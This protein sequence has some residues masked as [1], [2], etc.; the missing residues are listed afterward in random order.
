M[1]FL[2]EQTIPI[3]TKDINSWIFDD[4]SYDPNKPVRFSLVSFRE[5]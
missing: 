1:V 5:S 3:P 2:A 4:V